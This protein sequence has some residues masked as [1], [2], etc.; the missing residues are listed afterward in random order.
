MR[1]RHI[2]KE[3]T[4]GKMQLKSE[5]KRIIKNYP[6]FKSWCLEIVGELKREERDEI[7]TRK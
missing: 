7:Q 5:N 1:Y 3:D 2:N 6:D 4:G